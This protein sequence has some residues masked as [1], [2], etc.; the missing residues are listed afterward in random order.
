MTTTETT[1]RF[2]DYSKGKI[3]KIIAPDTNEVYI[4]STIQTL[5]QRLS[6]HTSDARCW[7]KDNSKKYCWSEMMLRNKGYK[8][9]L[10]YDYPCGSLAE[11]YREEGETAKL[12]PNRVNTKF[13]AGRT[14][15]EW[16][17]DN[18]TTGADYL[19]DWRESNPTNH[20]QHSEN[21]NQRRR[22]KRAAA[23]K[24]AEDIIKAL[25]K[26]EQK[27]LDIKFKQ[28]LEDHEM[29]NEIL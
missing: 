17:E 20:K 18:N 3:Y 14:R 12:F 15:E 16:F 2:R 11:L 19:R 27:R 26:E 25:K 7:R 4:G 22:E 13:V 10:L 1:T 29:E 21:N 28:D 5:A 8:I 24:D 6:K 9:E 23:K